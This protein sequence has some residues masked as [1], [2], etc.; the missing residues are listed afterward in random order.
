MRFGI[1]GPLEV[2]R[3]GVRLN[4]GGVRRRALLARLLLDAR[5]LVTAERLIDAIWEERPPA[6][7]HKTLQKYV[8]ELRGVLA[9]SVLRTVPGGYVLDV[10]DEDLDVR[11]FERLVKQ[12]EFA[13]ALALWRG[14][15]LADLGDIG[16]AVAER[17]RLDEL[18]LAAWQGRIEA[19]LAGGR[20]AEAIT[21]LA[22]LCAVYPNREPLVRLHMLALYQSGRQ[23]DALEIFRQHR[24]RLSE[25]LGVEPTKE[26][27]DLHVAMLRQEPTLAGPAT[28]P[29]LYSRRPRGILPQALS[30][31]VGRDKE[32]D[33]VEHTLTDNRLVTLSGPG[34]V[35]KTRLAVEAATR[36]Q[37][38][39]DGGAWLV[40]LAEITTPEQV[41]SA[42]ALAL[43]V[44]RRHAPDEL[45]A[46]EARLTYG[47]PCLIVLDNC[48]HL[49]G[50][51]SDL[52]RRVLPR[53]PNVIV[54]ATSRRPLGIDGEFEM[55]VR[56]L[57]AEDSIR[58]F[59]DR[60][61]L[62]APSSY[63][64]GSTEEV[65]EICRHLDGL[66]LAIELAASQLRVLH[67]GELAARMS[68][69]LR[70]RGPGQQST[71]R[72]ATLHARV[73]WSYDLIPDLSQL[74]FARLGV[75]MG[76]LTIAGAEAVCADLALAPADVLTQVTIL[77][78]H[79]LLLRAGA[80]LP[81]SRFR[82][83]ETLRLFA[84]ERLAESGA[85]ESTRRAHASYFR[86]LAEEAGRNIY[87]R[88]ERIWQDRLEAE[89]PNL[90]AAMAWAAE[91]DWSA[92]VDLAVALWPYWDAGWGERGAV[93]YL[94]KLL[95]VA[96]DSVDVERRAW[97]LVVA[98]DMAANQGDARKAVPWARQALQP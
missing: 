94:D 61:R 48:E 88:D 51:C 60:G 85:A 55:T 15:V 10:D 6:T 49:A 8:F 96:D 63:D 41:P 58:L 59:I 39:F 50:A 3:D 32:L 67:L 64:V 5:H 14:E 90:E 53:C 43:G 7:A 98:A 34:G 70:F 81:E 20:Y 9:E 2:V 54:L 92:A 42:V 21:R 29:P 80:P 22:E 75:F 65:A 57:N 1:L 33:E 71:Q 38:R 31:F 47:D 24:Y 13:R 26:L 19:D 76:S 93:A 28:S 35:G 37:D 79:S 27:Q 18:R 23:A 56:S 44:D 77:V 74:V 91:Y 46:I 97:A 12:S 89:K 30:S 52:L 36:A 78:D 73:S 4:L 62:A 84:L 40:D 17:T 83:L 45:I 69:R 82:Q 68:D 95:A 72:Q 87:G 11:R 16:F 25:E 66:P 86:Q